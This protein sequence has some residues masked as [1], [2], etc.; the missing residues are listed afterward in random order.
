MLVAALS[1]GVA[2]GVLCIDIAVDLSADRGAKAMY[3][4]LILTPFVSFI[5]GSIA[6]TCFTL[7]LY[8]SL[9]APPETPPETLQLAETLVKFQSAMLLLYFSIV[10][11]EYV[12]VLSDSSS[13][14]Y[15]RIGA[16]HVALLI[17]CVAAIFRILATGPLALVVY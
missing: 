4:K 7:L 10:V 11:P 8:S 5:L 3:Y 15:A 13:A 17:L 16:T 12:R 2:F 9:C 6:L 14:D 1:F